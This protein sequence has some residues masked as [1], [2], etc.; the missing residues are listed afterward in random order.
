MDLEMTSLVDV[1]VDSIIELAVV[2]TDRDLNVIAEGQDIV[3]HADTLAFEA[4]PR[5]VL[6]IHEASGIIGQAAHSAISEGEAE[7]KVL[8]FLKEHV[9]EKSSPLCGNSI[10]VDRHFLRMRMPSIDAY[11]DYRVIDVS[12]VKE[13]AKRWNREAFSRYG[14]VKKHRAKDDILQSIEE[15]KFWRKEFLRG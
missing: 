13:L 9:A 2:L 5:D 7:Q 15:L 11:L 12:T 10:W 3:I 1:R 8:A 14:K 6:A 4:I